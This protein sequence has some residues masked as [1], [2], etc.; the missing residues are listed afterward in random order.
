[1]TT[2]VRRGNEVRRARSPWWKASDAVL[3][4]LDQVGFVAAPKVIGYDGETARLSF[5]PGV[6]A[7]ATL[8]GFQ[9]DDVLIAVGRLAREFHDAVSSFTG[10]ESIDWPV[11]IGAPKSDGTICHNDIAPW[12][13]I[14]NGQTP[15]ALIDW[16]LVGPGTRGWDLAYM[17]WRFVPLY[18]D[19]RFGTPTERMRRISVLL[20]AYEL[21]SS[22]RGG[23]VDLIRDRMYS[24]WETV[25]VWGQQGIPG[26][27]RLYR[28]NLH[29]DA[30]DH[31]AWLDKY[32]K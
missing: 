27:N 7:P 19:P 32:L 1:M 16:D 23:F 2:V 21:S 20:D 8:E 4:H 28:E 13:T 12:N 17:A 22:A 24:S 30:L 11:M 10:A 3:R 25:E 26:F 6:S 15:V 29:S 14:F 5:I 31:V 9:S 18:P